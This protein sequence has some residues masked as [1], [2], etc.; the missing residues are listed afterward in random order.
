M[1]QSFVAPKSFLVH[2]TSAR[3]LHRSDRFDN[4]WSSTTSTSRRLASNVPLTGHV[5]AHNNR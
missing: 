4:F 1:F 3:L 5:P 2:A